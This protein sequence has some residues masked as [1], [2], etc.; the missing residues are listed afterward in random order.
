MT[1]RGLDKCDRVCLAVARLGITIRDHTG[2]AD[3]S[4][5]RERSWRS[6]GDRAEAVVASRDRGDSGSGWSLPLQ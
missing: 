3:R 2:P 5:S 6:H 1:V 4:R